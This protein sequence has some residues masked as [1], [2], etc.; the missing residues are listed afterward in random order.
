MKERRQTV[1]IVDDSQTNV[2]VLGEALNEE[3]D[4]LVATSGREALAMAAA[5]NPDLI[6]LDIIMPD[7]D[8]YEVCERLKA[9][10]A[11]R[12]IPVIFVTSMSKDEDEERG[13]EIGG[14]DYITRPFS[15]PIIRARVRIHLEL[16]RYRDFLENLVATDGLTGIPNRRQFDE[17]MVKEW[18]RAIRNR[19]P[20]S[21]ILMDIDFFKAYNDHYGHLAGDDCLKRLADEL[22]ECV[23]RPSDLVAR[24]GGE[25]FACILPE[26]DLEGALLLANTIR[27][28]VK[29]LGIP[30][31]HSEAADH[32]TLSIGVATCTPEEGQ[33]ILELISDAD[34]LMYEAKR[35]GRDQVRHRTSE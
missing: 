7:M 13:L 28:R 30:H 32:I 33:S 19:M 26:T 2:M 18:R 5:H 23:R 10:P 4:L 16:K 6:L 3:H 22:R 21:L 8:G 29:A 31:T 12:D 11:T 34:D 20:I 14:M 9:D 17:F 1:L 25:E 24:Y 15:I 27:N 35:G